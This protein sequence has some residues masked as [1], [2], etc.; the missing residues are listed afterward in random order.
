[1]HKILLSI[2]ILLF[3]AGGVLRSVENSERNCNLRFEQAMKSYSLSFEKLK[4]NTQAKISMTVIEEMDGKLV[5]EERREYIYAYNGSLKTEQSNYTQ[6]LIGNKSVTINKDKKVIVFKKN[7]TNKK[8]NGAIL[9]DFFFKKLGSAVNESDFF[10][11]DTVIENKKYHKYRIIPKVK[12]KI[13]KELIFIFDHN[14][15]LFKYENILHKGGH[16]FSNSI[17]INE[18]VKE[19]PLLEEFGKDIS[20]IVYTKD[21]KIK[22]VY[23]S[24]RIIDHSFE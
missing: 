19:Q 11:N 24:Y 16:S 7:L 17:I 4:S 2:L 12:E 20:S 23:D 8:E 10:C 18:F 9:K 6:Y 13:S 5:K 1:M 15:I 14:N 22:K 3:S 21:K